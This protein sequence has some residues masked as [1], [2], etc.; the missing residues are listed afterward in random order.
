MNEKQRDSLWVLRFPLRWRAAIRA[1]ALTRQ[2]D[3]APF[4][5]MVLDAG[6]AGLTSRM[7]PPPIEQFQLGTFR[8]HN[9]P[10]RYRHQLHTE[11]IARGSLGIDR[12]VLA[13]L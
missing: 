13:L 9:V 4:V 7:V 11:A 5:M 1:E 2:I 10:Y 12:A 3:L 6:K 8:V